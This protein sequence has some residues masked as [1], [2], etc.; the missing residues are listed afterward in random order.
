MNPS[1]QIDQLI[2]GL[3]D[4]RGQTL[5]TLRK[6]ILAADRGIVEEWKWMGSPVWSRDGMI[7]VAN[8]HKGKVKI[9]FTNGASLPDPDRLFN[10]GL[11]GNKW[12]AI[13]L[14]E[15]DKIDAG[16]LKNLVRAAIA[17]NQDKSKK[18]APAPKRAKASQQDNA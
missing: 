18:K 1:E 4:W 10:A 2:A 12:R 15:G 11:G 16:A 17:F 14:A 13:D 9:T 7:A 3:T 8:A 6:T 5:A